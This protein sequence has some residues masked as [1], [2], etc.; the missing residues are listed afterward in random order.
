MIFDASNL[1][2]LKI[3][4]IKGHITENYISTLHI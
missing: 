3:E 2:K 4:V 1:K